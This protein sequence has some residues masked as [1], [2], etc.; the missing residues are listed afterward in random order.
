MAR[1]ARAEFAGAVYHVLD[2]GDRREAIFRDD[3]D[4]EA[5]LATLGQACLRTGWRVHA[6]VLMGNHYHVLIETPHPNLVAGMRWFQTTITARFNR[7]HRLCGHLFQGRYKSV[8]IDPEER[9]YVVTVSDYIHLN[10]VRAGMIGPEARLFDF[11]WSSY[12]HYVRRNSRPAWLAVDAVLG[13]LGLRDDGAGRLAYAQGMRD[14]ALATALPGAAEALK[15]LR[16]QWCL[17]GESFRERMLRLVD[18]AME[19]LRW[20]K[21]T[22]APVQRSHD[23]AEAENLVAAGLARLGLTN[24]ELPRLKKSDPRKMAL[25]GFVRR[26]TAVSNRWLAQRLHLGHVSQ[27]SRA[28]ALELPSKLAGL[29]SR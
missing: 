16:Q 11:R 4:R 5:F 1:K 20:R 10:P 28:G 6:Y 23:E 18:G 14:R 24:E 17:G 21:G 19:K 13:E 29:A 26:E 7:R 15:E 9:G 27:V 25:A 3:R 22:D 12:P 2:R 8:V